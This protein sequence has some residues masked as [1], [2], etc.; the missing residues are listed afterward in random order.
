MGANILLAIDVGGTNLKIGVITPSYKIIYKEVIKTCLFKNSAQLIEA[1][2]ASIDN[3][4][5]EHSIERTSVL[6]LGLGLPGP[7]DPQKGIV[8]F[9]PN[10]P[11]W[12][13]VPLK[14][15]LE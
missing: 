4:L 6:G 10:I 7:V 8:H 3:V 9:L 1:I 12:R 14:K 5:F 2:A 11:G 13:E 15:L